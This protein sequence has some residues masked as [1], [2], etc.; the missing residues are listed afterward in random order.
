MG[1]LFV[2]LRIASDSTNLAAQ[3]LVYNLP[4]TVVFFALI[5]VPDFFFTK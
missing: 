3:I 2:G 5:S 4:E 1:S